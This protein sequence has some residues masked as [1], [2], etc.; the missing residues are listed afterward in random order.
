[1]S[2]AL[3]PCKKYQVEYGKSLA[4]SYE[5]IE[6][7]IDEIRYKDG[8]FIPESEDNI[9]IN[10]DAVEAIIADTS[11]SKTTRTILQKALKE[12]DSNNDFIRMEIF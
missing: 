12:C 6:D 8:V 1:M 2:V 9:E 3:K 5:K 7:F 10:T 4:Y 11:V